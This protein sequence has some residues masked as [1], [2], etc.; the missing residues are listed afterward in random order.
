MQCMGLRA[1]TACT[2]CIQRFTMRYDNFCAQLVFVTANL[3][4]ACFLKRV[5]QLRKYV[6]SGSNSINMK[7]MTVMRVVSCTI[8]ER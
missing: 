8:R 4:T 7:Q 5:V 3:R 2:E 1:D 6:H